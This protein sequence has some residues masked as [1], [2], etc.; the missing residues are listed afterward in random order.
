MES[1][2]L[3]CCLLIAGDLK[4]P[5]APSVEL[6]AD[7]PDVKV[8]GGGLTGRLAAGTAA[9]GAALGAG[10]MAL[11]GK[12]S[13]SADVKVGLPTPN[14]CPPDSTLLKWTWHKTD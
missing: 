11:S 7:A 5:D 1:T 4:G 14:M 3:L 12:G 8:E 2:A 10:V 6:G 13:A 9:V